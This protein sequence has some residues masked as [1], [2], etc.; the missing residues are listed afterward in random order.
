MAAS[1]A[2]VAL[3]AWAQGWRAADVTIHAR[4]FSVA[5]QQTLIAVADTIIPEGNGIGALSV[6]VD[7][8]LEKL[9]TDCYE[10]DVKD[11]IQ[12]QLTAL[13]ANAQALHQKPFKDCA[14]MARE[15]MLMQLAASDNTAQQDFFKL[16]KAETVRGFRTSREVLLNYFDY[17]QAPGHFY[18][19]V[20][21]NA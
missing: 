3:P 10:Q 13:D 11:N 12:T 1:G 6:G 19:C 15:E 4:V 20:D 9:F 17:K 16:M 2:L 14:Q 7:K 5:A 8:F 21:V 18:G